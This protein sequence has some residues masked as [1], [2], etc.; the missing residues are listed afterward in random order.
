MNEMLQ[1]GSFSSIEKVVGMKFCIMY[2]IGLNQQHQ[3][4]KL[5]VNLHDASIIH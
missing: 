1:N 3:L 2:L 4:I 5:M